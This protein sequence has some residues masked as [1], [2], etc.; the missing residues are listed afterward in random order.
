MLRFK[1]DS[2]NSSNRQML[3]FK[4]DSANSANRRPWSPSKYNAGIPALS[5]LPKKKESNPPD[6]KKNSLMDQNDENLSEHQTP[7]DSRSEKNALT[8]QGSESLDEHQSTE[9]PNSEE[10]TLMNQND[11]DLSEHQTSENSRSEKN[12]LTNQGGESLDEH[13]ST[14]VPNSEDNALMNPYDGKSSLAT[15]NPEDSMLQQPPPKADTQKD[16]LFFTN[17]NPQGTN[18][19]TI[20]CCFF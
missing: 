19:K 2:A 16:A 9:V 12:A 4:K 11:E 13:Q 10:N 14:E 17:K 18:E 1:K 3:R 20:C 15:E 5:P 8:N 6:L 7:E